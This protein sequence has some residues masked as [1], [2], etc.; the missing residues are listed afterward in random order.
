MMTIYTH[1]EP[2]DDDPLTEEQ[3]VR[4]DD[5]GIMYIVRLAGESSE[6]ES[7]EE[8]DHKKHRIFG[9]SYIGRAVLGNTYFDDE[10]IDGIEID[11]P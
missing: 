4:W 8:E 7:S 2:M 1:W 6:E 9:G 10:D 11:Y 3:E 5:D